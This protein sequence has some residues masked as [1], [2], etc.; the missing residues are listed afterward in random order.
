MVGIPDSGSHVSSPACLV[1]LVH[2]SSQSSETCMMFQTKQNT[3]NTKRSFIAFPKETIWVF[4]LFLTFGSF[5]PQHLPSKDGRKIMFIIKSNQWMLVERRMQAVVY[6]VEVTFFKG[7]TTSFSLRGFFGTTQSSFCS[8]QTS[9]IIHLVTRCPFKE[10]VKIFFFRLSFFLWQVS[11]DC[12]N[13]SNQWPL[14]K[15]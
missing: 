2:Q 3:K 15:V 11:K 6:H 1:T 8:W 13:E 4:L 12:M 9:I 10:N 14:L 7:T 5:F